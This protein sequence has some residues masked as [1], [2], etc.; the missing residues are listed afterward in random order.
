MA[1][2]A[3][4]RDLTP[5]LIYIMIYTMTIQK[6]A[7]LFQNGRSQAVRLPREYRF[8]GPEVLIRREGRC[9]VLE[10]VE[11]EWPDGFWACLGSVS[12][13]FERH[14]PDTPDSRDALE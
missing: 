1:S 9:V 5:S 7:K 4:D 13:D 14:Q 6:R 10:P 2:A 11:R 8:P 12:D 3:D